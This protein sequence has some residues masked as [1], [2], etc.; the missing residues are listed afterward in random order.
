MQCV[1]HNTA[2]A[3]EQTLMSTWNGDDIQPPFY[4][5][6]WVEGEEL[7][8][9]A[10]RE[11]AACI[12]PQAK[13]GEFQE[14]LWRYDVVEFFIATPDAKRYLEFNL[15]P[16]GAWW[17]AGFTEP[18]V[19]LPGFDAQELSPRTRGHLES[20]RWE[21]EARI[22]LPRLARWGW[23]PSAPRRMAVCAVI[24]RDGQYTYLTTC[25]QRAGRP[26]FHHPW[27]WETPRGVC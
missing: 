6:F 27:D 18:R 14:E 3:G 10:R 22:P 20:T 2:A 26:D 7:A 17:A 9:R 13:E 19:A 15:C 5:S 16:N 24:C 12:H 11:A 8:F 21:C 4:Y 23:Q 1:I 25:E